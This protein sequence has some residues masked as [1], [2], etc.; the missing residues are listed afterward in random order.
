MSTTKKLV[1]GAVAIVFVLIA[2]LSFG[3]SSKIS[4]TLGQAGWPV[5]NTPEIFSSGIDSGDGYVSFVKGGIIGP[6]ANQASWRNTTGRTVYVV[7]E[8]VAVGFASGT[9]SSSLL[10]YAATSSAATLTSDFAHPGGSVWAIDGASVAT[11]TPGPSFIVGTTT[12][13]GAG[14]PIADGAYFNVQIQS[15]NGGSCNGAACET[16]TS[17]NRGVSNFF[18]RFTGFYKP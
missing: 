1:L 9:A 12:S 14:V 7:P 10:Y 16:A 15:K 13:S 5:H 2:I 18:W 17:T 6:G 8:G 11:S 4:Q 3:G